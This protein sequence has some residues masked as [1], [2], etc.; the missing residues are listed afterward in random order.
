M[1]DEPILEMLFQLLPLSS[2]LIGKFSGRMETTQLSSGRLEEKTLRN[3]L[4]LF[5]YRIKSSHTVASATRTIL[6]VESRLG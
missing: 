1:L 2:G 3:F 6:N 4:R 5:D